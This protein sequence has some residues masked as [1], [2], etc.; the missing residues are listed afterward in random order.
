MEV[1]PLEQLGWRIMI[2]GPTNSGKSTLAHALGVKLGIP[3]VHVDLLRHLPHTDWKQRP[4]AQFHALHAAAIA[5]PEWVMDGNYSALMPARY[6]RATGVVVLDERLDV[7]FFRYVRRTL[8]QEAR[9]GA[10]EGRRDSIKW[11]MI[12]WIWHT[13]RS[14]ATLRQKAAQSGLPVVT[15]AGRGELDALYAAWDLRRP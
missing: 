2:C 1:V 14:A 5:E 11:A 13:R 7:R 6:A 4:D 3:A 15:V 8:W 12:H 10:L 9:T